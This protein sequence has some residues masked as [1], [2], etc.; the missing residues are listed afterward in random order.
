M[1]ER[2]VTCSMSI[3]DFSFNLQVVAPLFP[4]D[5]YSVVSI[6]VLKEGGYAFGTVVN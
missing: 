5:H 6:D 3:N 1:I 4:G 2:D